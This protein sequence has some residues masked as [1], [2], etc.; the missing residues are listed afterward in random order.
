VNLLIVVS[1][2]LLFLLQAPGSQWFLNIA[3]GVFAT[4]HESDLTR[5]VGRDGRVGI[6][7]DRE[8]F[9]AGL[10]EGGD[11]SKMK[12]LILSCSWPR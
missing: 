3:V 12:P 9:L 11:K 2:Q 10:L 1:A 5:R 7:D 4:D 8:D 6:F